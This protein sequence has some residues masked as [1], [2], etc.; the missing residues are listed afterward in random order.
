MSY[1]HW[2]GLRMELPGLRRVS[3]ASLGLLALAST[4][5]FEG[6]LRNSSQDPVIQRS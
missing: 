5:W 3:R 6:G 4:E 2:K 1:G